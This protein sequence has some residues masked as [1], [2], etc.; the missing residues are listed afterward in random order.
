MDKRTIILIVTFFTMVVIGMF[1]F[2]YLK[3]AEISNPAPEP[4]TNSD[5]TEQVMYPNITRIDAKHYYID[6]VHTY[7]GQLEMPTPC[8]LVNVDSSVAESF[9]EQITL[10]FSVINNSEN[11]VEMITAQRFMVSANASV[12]ASTKAIFMGREVELNLIP[13]A[14]GETPEEFELYIKG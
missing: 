5:S 1:I 4:V 6:G 14:P 9:P 3:R 13:A 8:D 10:N 2:A 12:E 7:V 11:C